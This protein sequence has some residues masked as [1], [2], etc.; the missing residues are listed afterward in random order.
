MIDCSVK[1]KVAEV[2]KKVGQCL[3]ANKGNPEFTEVLSVEHT[4]TRAD[5]EMNRLIFEHLSKATPSIPIFSEE[6][7]HSLSDRPKIL[8][9]RSY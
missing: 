6:L 2:L 5:I 1:N 3:I 8:V 4:K 9:D 7:E